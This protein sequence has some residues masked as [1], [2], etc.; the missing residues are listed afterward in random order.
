MF[1]RVIIMRAFISID[2]K[3]EVISELSRIQDSIKKLSELSPENK[4][5]SYVSP[6]I[7]HLTLKFLGDITEE[8][9][10]AVEKN[11]GSIDKEIF[12]ALLGEIGFIPNKHRPRV[13]YVSLEPKEKT[14]ELHDII[15]KKLSA[16]DFA[17]DFQKFEHGSFK[18]HVTLAR[19]KD[20]ER[21]DI[22][23][24]TQSIENIELMHKS[25]KI[26]NFRLKKSTLK[27]KGPVYETLEEFKL[28]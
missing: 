13:I 12:D 1:V 24:F 7:L 5:I 17:K 25:F 19:I 18:S 20:I 8:Q 27:P 11:L 26:D 21:N 28:K 4:K 9:E 14:T 6:D 22:K 10:K 3:P 23:S 16:S 2:L 15:D